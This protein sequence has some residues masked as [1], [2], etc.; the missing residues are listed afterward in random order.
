MAH[1]DISIVVFEEITL[2]VEEA[3]NHY[4]LAEENDP[5]RFLSIR[6][7]AEVDSTFAELA[8][9]GMNPTLYVP[10]P[11]W[12]WGWPEFS[13]SVGASTMLRAR[14]DMAW[15]RTTRGAGRVR[16]RPVARSSERRMVGSGVKWLAG[17]R[18]S[19]Y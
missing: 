19:F 4:E 16:R 12:G 7:S 6:R 18:I 15:P 14:L 3:I 11:S 13:V 1:G 5:E 8:E 10:K 9:A 17:R 2:R